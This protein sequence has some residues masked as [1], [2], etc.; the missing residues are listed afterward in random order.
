MRRIAIATG[1]IFSAIVCGFAFAT[2]LECYR[3]GVLVTKT[4]NVPKHYFL[5]LISL[6]YLFLTLEFGREFFHDFKK[7]GGKD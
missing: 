7:T 3:T 2:A 4:L 6:G 5:W 1:V